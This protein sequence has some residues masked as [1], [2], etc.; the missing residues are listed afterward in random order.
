MSTM[1]TLSEVLNTL[2]ARG[3]TVDFNLGE[4]CLIC[5]GD[6]L[7]IHPEDFVVD[8]YYRFEGASDPEDEAI[9]YA[10]S[11]AR[12][13]LKGTLI[14]GYGIYSDPLTDEMTKALDTRG[15]AAGAGA[16]TSAE[17]VKSNQATPQRPE[18]DRPLNASLVIMDLQQRTSQVKEEPAWKN[19]DRNAITLFKSASMRVVLIA[20]R[21]G[22]E[23]KTHTAPGTI[24][25]QVLEGRIQFHTEAQAVDLEAGRMLV[26]HT[27]IPHSVLAEKESVFLLTLS[28]VKN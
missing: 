19:G 3:Y 10:I 14:N 8:K 7:K 24:S 16:A 12:H 22:A 6:F 13:N 21:E 27:S 25:V 2:K 15:V 5:N 11:S 9:V 1:T 17:P 20:L 28:S 18:G 4:N 23:I 26:L